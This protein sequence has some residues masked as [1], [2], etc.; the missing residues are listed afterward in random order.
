MG[1]S[2]IPLA[3]EGWEKE[4]E[5]NSLPDSIKHLT[6]LQVGQCAAIWLDGC[7]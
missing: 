5:L 1:M 6:E 7:W 3:L 4:L 2:V